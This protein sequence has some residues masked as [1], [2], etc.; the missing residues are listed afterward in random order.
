MD[1]QIRLAN[2][3]SNETGRVEIFHPSFGW[4]TVCDYGWDDSDSR[5]V[6]RQ[7]GFAGV[8]GTRKGAY[9][10]E[11]TGSTLLVDVKCTGNESFIW[12]CSHRGWNVENCDH[13][14]DVGVDCNGN[15]IIFLYIIFFMSML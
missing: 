9:F 6:C 7:L 10:G 5:V 11:G 8:S 13:S 4:G 3:K 12:D 1:L 15:C 2:T 14:D